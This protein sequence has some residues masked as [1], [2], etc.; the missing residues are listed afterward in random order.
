MTAELD[1]SQAEDIALAEIAK[2]MFS[3][4]RTLV[5]LCDL[6][7]AAAAPVLFPPNDTSGL[8]PL[9]ERG[10]GLRCGGLCPPHP[11]PACKISGGPSGLPNRQ[12]DGVQIAL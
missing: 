11:R 12:L 9:Y 1:R 3:E 10:A 7:V 2:G 8:V 5:R 6:S 4:F